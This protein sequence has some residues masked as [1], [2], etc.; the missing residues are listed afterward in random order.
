[1]KMLIFCCIY[2]L[3]LTLCFSEEKYPRIYPCLPMEGRVSQ[4]DDLR[5]QTILIKHGLA[6][7][8]LEMQK[9]KV[10][11]VGMYSTQTLYLRAKL[12]DSRLKN[13]MKPMQQTYVAV[14][15]RLAYGEPVE[16]VFWGTKLEDMP[17]IVKEF[18]VRQIVKFYD[19]GIVEI[20]NL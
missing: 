15:V 4:Q 14:L 20:M 3:C 16:N 9:N 11:M 7:A 10:E 12:G 5:M 6:A 1:M 18:W 19:S 13:K 17:S 8:D 2:L